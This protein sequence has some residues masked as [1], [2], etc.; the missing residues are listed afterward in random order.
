MNPHVRLFCVS[1]VVIGLS[2]GVAYA[3]SIRDVADFNDGTTQG[4][5]WS[6][7][8]TYVGTDLGP[9][10]AGDHALIAPPSSIVYKFHVQ[11]NANDDFLG[12]WLDADGGRVSGIMFDAKLE[13]GADPNAPDSLSLYATSFSWLQDPND[14]NGSVLAQY[15]SLDGSEV[16]VP[17]DGTWHR[18]LRISLRQEDLG[19]FATPRDFYNHFENIAFCG[20]RHQEAEGPGGTSML[21]DDFRVLVDNIRLIGSCRT[22]LDQDGQ[23]GLSDLAQM[24]ANYGMTTG[25]TIDDGDLDGDGDVDLSDLAALL[26]EYGSCP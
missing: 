16:V 17:D 12:D 8:I 1:L 9:D 11:T 13:G 24:L 5:N 4:W 10:G 18:N 22:D 21:T 25:A 23:V 14:P 7:E 6:G 2:L 3:A 26:A 15:S 20:L 19:S